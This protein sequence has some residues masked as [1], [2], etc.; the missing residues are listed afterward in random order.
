[1]SEVCEKCQGKMYYFINKNWVSGWI[2]STCG[3]CL[4][5]EINCG[6]TE[7][8]KSSVTIRKL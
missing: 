7:L 4:T 8:I 2:C 6:N 1:M 3:F 5:T